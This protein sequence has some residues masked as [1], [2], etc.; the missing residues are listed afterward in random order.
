MS[1]NDHAKEIM[2]V[3]KPLME[4]HGSTKMNTTPS[5]ILHALSTDSMGLGDIMSSLEVLENEKY[6]TLKRYYEDIYDICLTDT[7]LNFYK[8]S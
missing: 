5:E 3:L 2:Y 7:G 8:E 1:M 4:K 6:I